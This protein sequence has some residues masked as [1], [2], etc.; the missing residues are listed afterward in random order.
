ME[1]FFS[2]FSLWSNDSF[3]QSSRENNYTVPYP[4]ASVVIPE[5]K[6]T[7]RQQACVYAML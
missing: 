5:G 4:G 6:H 7:D 2:I 1:I 3:W